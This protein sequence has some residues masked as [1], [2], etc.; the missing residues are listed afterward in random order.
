M[1][2]EGHLPT[3][4]PQEK[5][6]IR[7]TYGVNEYRRG[8]MTVADIIRLRPETHRLLI[9]NPYQHDNYL[10]SRFPIDRFH[11]DTTTLRMQAVALAEPFAEYDLKSDR[12]DLAEQQRLL[13]T[14]ADMIVRMTTYI[15]DHINEFWAQ[16]PGSIYQKL[17][18]EVF[19]TNNMDQIAQQYSQAQ[20]RGFRFAII[21]F[22]EGIN[23]FRPAHNIVEHEHAPRFLAN[24]LL[25]HGNLSHSK[26]LTAKV[27]PIGVIF[28][29][30]DREYKKFLSDA[31]FSAGIFIRAETWTVFPGQVIVINKKNGRNIADVQLTEQHELMHLIRSSFFQRDR[32]RHIFNYYNVESAERMSTPAER[33][34]YLKNWARAIIA[35]SHE[36]IEDETIAYS[37][38]G[39]SGVNSFEN[40]DWDE[41]IAGLKRDLGEAIIHLSTRSLINQQQKDEFLN[42]FS[43]YDLRSNRQFPEYHWIV[44]QLFAKAQKSANGLTPEKVRA[45]LHLTPINKAR[46]LAVQYL[47]FADESQIPFA[48]QQDVNQRIA[49]IATQVRTMRTGKTI[50]QDLVQPVLTYHPVSSLPLLIEI[51]ERASDLSLVLLSFDA[52]VDMITENKPEIIDDQTKLRIYNILINNKEFKRAFPSLINYFNPKNRE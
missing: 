40:L 23:L 26:S 44:E 48:F 33:I 43:Y 9:A 14:S 25:K 3:F 29:L 47:G 12:V 5:F 36:R 2:Q 19:Q 4:S 30:D 31:K 6:Q 11:L 15:K 21:N 42:T 34:R 28:Y 46:R 50:T 13:N 8:L 18:Y 49:I 1:S 38:E 24:S 17:S 51:M 22:I 41:E 27:L 37:T 7:N 52:I 39:H 32:S 16:D 35:L 10:L 45:L 20:R